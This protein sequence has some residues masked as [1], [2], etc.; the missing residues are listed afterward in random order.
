MTFV[1]S[2]SVTSEIASIS[3]LVK[4]VIVH[5]EDRLDEEKLFDLRLILS[6]LM[7]NGCEHGNQNNR[8]KLVSVDLMMK[9]DLLDLVVKDEGKGISFNAQ[10][11]E[12]M[13]LSC[14]G[15]GLKLVS[16]LCD[17]MVIQDSEVHCIVYL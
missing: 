3:D 2:G 16:E 9:E 5:L 11:Y 4:N 13:Q 1:F 17:E 8:R 7:I 6:E 10:E 14:S 12:P 15:R